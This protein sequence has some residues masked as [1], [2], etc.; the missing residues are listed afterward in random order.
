[1]SP[2][3]DDPVTPWQTYVA[4]IVSVPS[5]GDMWS[6]TQKILPGT[7]GEIQIFQGML[8]RGSKLFTSE[9]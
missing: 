1:M 4:M 9:T 2:Q 6:F 7:K 3:E 8:D 5:Q